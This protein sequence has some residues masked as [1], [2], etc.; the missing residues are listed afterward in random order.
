MS[1]QGRR[2]Q[3]RPRGVTPASMEPEDLLLDLPDRRIRGRWIAPTA[4]DDGYMRATLVFLHEGLGCIEMW[5]DFPAKLCAA[6]GFAGFAY[7]RTGYGQSSP[8]PRPPGT[9]YMHIEAEEVLP[10]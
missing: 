9:A 7:D 4:R 10:R 8:W 3:D 1:L 6:T 2:W 5:R